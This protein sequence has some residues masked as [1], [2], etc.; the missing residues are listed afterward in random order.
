MEKFYILFVCALSLEEESICIRFSK[1]Y[2]IYVHVCALSRSVM[3]DSLQPHG[4]YSPPGSSIQENSP[5]K[6]IGVGCHALLQGIFPTQG[7]NP[8]L[9][10]CRQILYHLSHQGSPF[11]LQEILIDHVCRK[12]EREI[13]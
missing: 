13:V 1:G 2:G 3:S 10:H 11:T 8:G 7:L 9:P 12:R 4:F 5:G 6:N